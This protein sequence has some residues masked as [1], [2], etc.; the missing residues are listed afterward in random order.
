MQL[1]NKSLVD[2]VREL[3]FQ[4]HQEFHRR[5]NSSDK[6]SEQLLTGC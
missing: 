4:V 1:S 6:L 2:G 3:S 5:E